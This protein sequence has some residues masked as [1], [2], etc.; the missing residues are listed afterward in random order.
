MS[1]VKMKGSEAI[2]L[3]VKARKAIFAAR[4][5]RIKKAEVKILAEANRPVWY[6]P[7]KKPITMEEALKREEQRMR[8]YFTISETV[9]AKAWNTELLVKASDIINAV[10]NDNEREVLIDIEDAAN[11]R[12]WTY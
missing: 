11:L 1:Y 6:N 12:T 3:C 2:D 4:E 8:E 5:E 9:F 10:G 7:W